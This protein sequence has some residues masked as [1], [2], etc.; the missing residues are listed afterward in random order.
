MTH[1]LDI[2]LDLKL[3]DPKR[4]AL[5]R[6]NFNKFNKKFVK[7]LESNAYYPLFIGYIERN[8]GEILSEMRSYEVTCRSQ[9][10]TTLL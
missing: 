4:P 5:N 1:I 6:P 9:A 3:R 2:F 8:K 7:P 10:F